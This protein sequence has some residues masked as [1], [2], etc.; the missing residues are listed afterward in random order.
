MVR[1][2]RRNGVSEMGHQLPTVRAD[3]DV[4]LSAGAM[5]LMIWKVPAGAHHSEWV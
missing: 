2:L 4:R 3:G 1:H 5:Q